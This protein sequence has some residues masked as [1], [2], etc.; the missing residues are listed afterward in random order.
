[1][2]SK[3]AAGHLHEP[4]CFNDDDKALDVVV[5]VSDDNEWQKCEDGT[6]TGLSVGGGYA[7]GSKRYE[8]LD[9]SGKQVL[10]YTAIPSEISLVDRPMIQTATFRMVKVDG[11]TEEREFKQTAG[12]NME[13]TQCYTDAMDVLNKWAGQ[14][15]SDVSGAVYALQSVLSIYLQEK[16]EPDEPGA[17]EQIA[18][19]A[20]AIK[21]LKS[22]IVMEIQ[23]ASEGDVIEL[24]AKVGDLEKSDKAEPKSGT[25]EKCGGPMKCAKCDMGKADDA[26]DLQ[27]IE[28]DHAEQLRKVEETHSEALQKLEGE[29]SEAL[30]KVQAL[31]T[32]GGRLEKVIT[33]ALSLDASEGFD[34]DKIEEMPAPAKGAVKDVLTI[35]KTDDNG[36]G[37]NTAQAELLAKIAALADKGDREAVAMELIKMSHAAGPITPKTY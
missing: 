35:S 8:K 13:K 11:S 2:H 17:K 32:R 20:D 16:A 27:K 26:A 36:G 10:R 3:V 22:F 29:K 4:I 34:L 23:E 14:E 18:A 6:Y 1:M 24:A 9:S 30:E 5:K 25:C 31:E 7:E 33:S 19:L 15:I 37:A 28:S 21:A 12:G